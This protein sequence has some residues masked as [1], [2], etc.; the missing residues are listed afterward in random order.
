MPAPAVSV[1][2][3]LPPRAVP[4]ARAGGDGRAALRHVLKID[5][6]GADGSGWQRERPL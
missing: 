5:G 4:F 6:A 3:F 2:V 1:T